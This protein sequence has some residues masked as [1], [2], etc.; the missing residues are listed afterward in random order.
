MRKLVVLLFVFLLAG[1]A[2]TKVVVKKVDPD[3]V[4]HYS[5]L[6]KLGKVA[7]LYDTVAYVDKGE[8]IPMEVSLDS[9]L[10]GLKEKRIDFILKERIYFMLRKPEN[11]SPEEMSAL[12]SLDEGKLTK[13]S[14]AE[15]IRYF[16]N[17]MLSRDAVHWAPLANRKAMKEVLEIKRGSISLGFGMNKKEGIWSFLKIKMTQ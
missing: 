14:E 12:E 16:Q 15:R 2:Q 10:V 17:L 5:Q 4:V 1:C 7:S 6:S 13:M 8:T 3:R 9:D 11:L